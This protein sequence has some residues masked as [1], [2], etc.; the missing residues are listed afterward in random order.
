MSKRDFNKE[1]IESL[2][3]NPYTFSVS[4]KTIYFTIEFK[5]EFW[6]RMNSGIRPQQ[7]ILDLGFDP[8]VLG[9]TRIEGLRQTVKKQGKEANF[10][11]GQLGL[12]TA[13]PD[14]SKIP[15]NQKLLAMETELYYLRQEL[16]F[17][18]KILKVG[19]GPKSEV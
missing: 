16:E 6:K 13:H 1:E 12:M 5:K 14:Y 15:D 7:I 19:N 4:P 10:R 11:E 3:L 8:E 9:I 2:R 17:L 18:K